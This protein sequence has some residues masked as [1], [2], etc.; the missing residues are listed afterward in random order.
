M[1]DT[2]RFKGGVGEEL[3]Y[4][5]WLVLLYEITRRI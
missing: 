5:E 3:D 1:R 2:K 4:W